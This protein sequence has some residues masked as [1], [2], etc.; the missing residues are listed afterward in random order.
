[1]P[2]VSIT[3]TYLGLEVSHGADFGLGTVGVVLGPCQDVIGKYGYFIVQY[4][5]NC[6]F[7]G[8]IWSILQLSR[9]FV[10]KIRLRRAVTCSQKKRATERR[11]FSYG[12]WYAWSL[13]VAA[14]GFILSSIVPSL[15]PVTAL[16]FWIKYAVDY[17]LFQNKAFNPLHETSGLYAPQVV[18]YLSCIVSFKMIA[19]GAI[20]LLMQSVDEAPPCPEGGCLGYSPTSN[21]M[22]K[23]DNPTFFWLIV[24]HNSCIGAV[25]F[26]LLWILGESPG[27]SFAERSQTDD[28]VC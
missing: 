10:S 23:Y 13:S 12:Y 25:A 4:I 15:L 19:T 2:L 21:V 6:A 17:Y 8:N 7:F 9:Y 28:V 20:M 5:I 24:A 18:H 11:E 16:F 3:A 26:Q 22:L 27:G 1:M 14:I